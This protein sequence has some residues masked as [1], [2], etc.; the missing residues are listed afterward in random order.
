MTLVT[1]GTGL[2]GAHLL[3]ELSA[4]NQHLKALKRPGSNTDFTK[5]V[6]GYYSKNNEELF[7]KVQWVDGDI[8]DIHSLLDGLEDVDKVYHC[9]AIV[10]Y[11]PARRQEM[12]NINAHGTAN[13]VNACLEKEI[14]KLCYISSTAALAHDDG[15]KI[16]DESTK[17]KA[18]K[19]NSSYSISKY[20][21]EQE[22]W[23]GIAE[24][25][26]AVIINPSIVIGPGD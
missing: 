6:F 12:L 14:E 1:G 10:S 23:R 5:K 19:H 25:L 20:N 7:A 18:S 8:L 24:G 3:F 15:N 11:N 9:A 17:W 26:N 21:A 13:M 2:I 22:V 16:I 4:K